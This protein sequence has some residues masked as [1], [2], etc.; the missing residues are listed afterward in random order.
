MSLV[1]RTSRYV[2]ILGL[3]EGTKATSVADVLIDHLHGL[4]E[5]MRQGL[6]WDQGTEMAD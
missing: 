3:P 1:E 6:A 2:L 4:P 5:F